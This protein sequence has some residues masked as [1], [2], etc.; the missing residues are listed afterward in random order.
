MAAAAGSYFA[1]GE[2]AAAGAASLEGEA[3]A[4]AAADAVRVLLGEEPS[5]AGAACTREGE[6]AAAD[7]GAAFGGPSIVAQALAQPVP[8]RAAVG[9]HAGGSPLRKRGAESRA[10]RAKASVHVGGEE[11]GGREGRG[12][13]AEKGG[14]RGTHICQ[15]NTFVRFE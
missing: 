4:A 10:G 6:A 2:A 9:G 8:A 14:G 3:A 5:E 11:R 7:A 12:G 13:R 15:T 1:L